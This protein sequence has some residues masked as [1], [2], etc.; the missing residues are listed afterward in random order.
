MT[1]RTKAQIAR[2]VTEALSCD[3][4]QAALAV[5][6]LLGL[7]KERLADGESVLLSGFGKF[8]V[9]DKEAR[10]GRNPAT[11]EP[12]EIDGRR[13]VVFRWSPKLR[14]RINRAKV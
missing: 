14:E 2:K 6:A 13:V 12:I 4:R 1:I 10:P 7:V 3:R 5:D 8:E 9:L 11:G